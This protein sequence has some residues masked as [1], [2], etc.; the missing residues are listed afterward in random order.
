[1]FLVPKFTYWYNICKW[2]NQL[3]REEHS[4][5]G[6]IPLQK[7]SQ[8]D[9]QSLLYHVRTQKKK[10]RVWSSRQA[11]TRHQ[12]CQRFDFGHPSLQNYVKQISAVYNIVTQ[13]MVFCYNSPN[14]LSH[15]VFV[16]LNPQFCLRCVSTYI[17]ISMI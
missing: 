12:M 10:K 14:R 8:K 4:W 1:M 6:L 3:M 13:F 7:R 16:D 11:L 5:M 15:L 2:G 17:P 9:P